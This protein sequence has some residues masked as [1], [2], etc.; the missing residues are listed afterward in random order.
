MKVLTDEA[1]TTT[2][3]LTAAEKK[4]VANSISIL[5]QVAFY[6]ADKQVQADAVHGRN[7]CALVLAEF[8]TREV[9][10]GKIEDVPEKEG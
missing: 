5:Q 4:K 2:V 9:A 10:S 8:A 6:E 1:G 7:G 3:E